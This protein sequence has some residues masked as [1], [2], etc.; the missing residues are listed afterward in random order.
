MMDIALNGDALEFLDANRPMTLDEEVAYQEMG[1]LPTDSLPTT[2]TANA[3]AVIERTSTTLTGGK[4][5][6]STD[7]A[8]EDSSPGKRNR[9]T[10]SGERSG[11]APSVPTSNGQ[12]SFMRAVS[13]PPPT[14]LP[15]RQVG[16]VVR[17]KKAHNYEKGTCVMTDQEL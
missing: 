11:T 10:D 8:S 13:Q 5:Q 14:T 4:Q 1:E 3:D 15:G 12:S 9:T 6:Q 7:G 2:I 16:P 17:G